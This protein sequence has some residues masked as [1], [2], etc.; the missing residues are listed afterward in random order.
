MSDKQV[1]GM[2][3]APD[4]LDTIVALALKEVAGIAHVGQA[5]SKIF[6]LFSSKQEQGVTVN[7]VS[8]DAVDVSVVVTVLDGLS[9]SKIASDARQ[10]IADAVLS[11]TGYTVNRVDIHVDGILFQD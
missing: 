9:L 5:S 8:E 7:Q 6:P 4:V 3:I 2:D 10:A 11:Q 1:S